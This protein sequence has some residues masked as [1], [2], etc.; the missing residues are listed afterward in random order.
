MVSVIRNKTRIDFY[1]PVCIDFNKALQ[2]LDF[3][4]ILHFPKSPRCRYIFSTQRPFRL[5]LSLIE[6]VDA[7]L[8]IDSRDSAPRSLR[9]S[10]EGGLSSGIPDSG[11]EAP[12]LLNIFGGGLFTKQNTLTIL[13]N[14]YQAES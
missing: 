13:Y 12:R 2:I 7:L 11:S 8:P 10:E 9:P 1:A 6:G 14:R 4:L 3:K 5:T